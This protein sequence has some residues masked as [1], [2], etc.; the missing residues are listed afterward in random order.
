MRDQDVFVLADTALSSVVSQIGAE[1]WDMTMP[2]DFPTSST[3]PLTLRAVVDQ[4]AYEDAWVPD[5]LAGR[6]MDDVGADAYKGD[7]L[8][9]DRI[10]AFAAIVATAVASVQAFDD[11]DLENVVH[12]SFGDFSAHDFLLQC[13]AFRGLR[14]R[15]IALV[16]GVDPTLPDELVQGLWEEL[17][18][19]ADDW[20]QWGVFPA[21]IEVPADAPL[22]AR[23]LGLVGRSA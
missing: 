20:R 21:R 3:E 22:L 7:L 17:E 16:I 11:A 8:G 10:A 4:H 13:N 5:M 1:Q 9:E 18:P 19:V 15:E 12:C 6:T 14:A 23:L 2:A